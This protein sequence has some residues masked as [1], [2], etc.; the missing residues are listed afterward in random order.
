MAGIK[1]SE[2]EDKILTRNYPWYDKEVTKLLPRRTWDAIKLRA[3]KLGLQFDRPCTARHINR[4]LEETPEAYYWNG[5]LLADGSFQERGTLS[6][7]LG[8]EDVEQVK[9]FGSFIGKDKINNRSEIGRG[10]IIQSKKV[11]FSLMEKFNYKRNKTKDPPVDWDFQSVP[12]DLLVSHL[13]GF[14][15]GDGSILRQLGRKVERYRIHIRIDTC[16]CEWL[17]R[18]IEEIRGRTG[19]SFGTPY[20]GYDNRTE[21]C[22]GSYKTVKFFRDFAKLHNLPVLERKWGKVND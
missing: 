2:E 13:I 7:T 12:T 21:C 6:F 9:H 1:W 5:F 15:D 20:L 19:F 10:I 11:S 3:V 4:L 8:K 17:G 16:W 22:I 14:I 18:Y